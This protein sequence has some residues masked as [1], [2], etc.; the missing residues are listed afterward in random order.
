MLLLFT[1]FVILVSLPFL[2]GHAG[3]PV[4]GR[5]DLPFLYGHAG[6]PDSGRLDLPF[7]IS[8]LFVYIKRKQFFII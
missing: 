5:L 4:S 7:L 1:L 6:P 8:F 3:P 2:Y